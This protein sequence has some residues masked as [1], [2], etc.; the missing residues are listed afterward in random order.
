[1]ATAIQI[2][3]GG[4]G[5]HPLSLLKLSSVTLRET[6]EV[7]ILN[8]NTIALIIRLNALDRRPTV[9]LGS[10]HQLQLWFPSEPK[11]LFLIPRQMS[12][13]FKIFGVIAVIIY[14]YVQ[15]KQFRHLSFRRLT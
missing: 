11:W 4:H 10:P 6:F 15:N 13:A 2:D 12:K 14:M 7:H 8:L 9:E 1:M 5:S 3:S